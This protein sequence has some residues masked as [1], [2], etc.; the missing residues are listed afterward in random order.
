L[1]RSAGVLAAV[2]V[3][4][5]VGTANATAPGSRGAKS[6]PRIVFELR[7]RYFMRPE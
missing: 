4:V 7:K 5:L 3:A 6:Q 2:T 1:I